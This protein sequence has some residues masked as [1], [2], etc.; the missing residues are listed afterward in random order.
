MIIHPELRA[1]RDDDSPQRDAQDALIR[2]VGGWRKRPHVARLLEEIAA[3]GKGGDLAGFP[4]LAALFDAESQDARHLADEVISLVA[5]GLAEHRLGHVPFRHFTDDVISTLQLA[6]SGNVTLSLVALSDEGLAAR[7]KA[8]TADFSPSEVWE[9]VLSGT[10][11]AAVIDRGTTSADH[12]DLR[13]SETDLSPG[14]VVIRD[15]RTRNMQVRTISG[16]LCSL[17][18]Q[19]RGA[20]A[21]P[22]R[23][24]NLD[25]GMLVHQAAGNPQ[26]SRIELMMALAGR[27]GRS[28]AAPVLAEI[29]QEDG[30]ASLRWQALREGLALDTVTGFLALTAVSRSAS[31]ELAPAAGALRSQLIETYPQLQE[32]A[33][34]PA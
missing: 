9:H 33:A 22:T 27:M 14:T 4:S 17:R 23:E 25:D 20:E 1:L 7:P 19:R 10:A 6:K 15:A 31:D 12:A 34:C 21:E 28:D 29:A 3:F 8:V 5:D 24:Y 32:L 16:C 11:R 2:L 30:S 26:D 13:H 18:L